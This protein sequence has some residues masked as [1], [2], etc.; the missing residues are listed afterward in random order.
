[1]VL[2]QIPV[3]LLAGLKAVMKAGVE[4]GA[5]RVRVLDTLGVLHPAATRWWIK[6]LKKAVNVPIQYHCHNDFGNA[7]MNACAAVE[8]GAEILDLVVNGLGDR[9]GN[10]NMEE[11][12]M[13]LECLYR[14][15]TGFKLEK[16]MDLSKMVEKITKVTMPQNKPIVGYNNFVHESDIHV[17]AV[18]QGYS[19]TF[20]PFKPE[21]VGQSRQIWFGSTTSSDSVIALAESRKLKFDASR[22]NDIL[23]KIKKEIEKKGYASD[24]EV[25][26]MIRDLK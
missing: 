13:A 15:D 25:E 22:A 3:R 16:L 9:A 19:N 10:T 21:L 20:E 5:T 18:L 24:A 17:A 4:A 6:E 26:K 7:V 8:G 1:M 2:T 12:V 11:T 14:V 23:D